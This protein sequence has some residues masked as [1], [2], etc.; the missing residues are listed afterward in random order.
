MS[1]ATLQWSKN[2]NLLSLEGFDT[3]D[4]TNSHV[5]KILSL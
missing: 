2:I 3:E 4:A 5:S 1:F